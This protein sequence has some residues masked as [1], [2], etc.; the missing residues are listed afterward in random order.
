MEIIIGT[1][2]YVTSA[3]ADDYFAGRP[4]SSEWDSVADASALL[5]L[6]ARIVDQQRFAGTIASAAQA[7]AWPRSG[8]VDIEGRAVPS[9]VVPE[10]IKTAQF[11]MALLLERVD[12]TADDGRAV[13]RRT[14]VDSLTIEYEPRASEQALP[15]FVAAILAPYLASGGGATSVRIAV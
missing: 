5:A 12:L 15:E 7:M 9:S 2:S 14:V 11:E 8:V 6:A 10:A 13:I 3:Q 1:N 4:Y